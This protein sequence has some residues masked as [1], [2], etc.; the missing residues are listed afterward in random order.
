MLLI[1]VGH[2][3]DLDLGVVGG[4]RGNRVDLLAVHQNLLQG[5][6][7]S[8]RGVHTGDILLGDQDL[9]L[10]RDR[11]SIANLNIVLVVLDCVRQLML[12]ILV[13]HKVDLDLGV[14]GGLRGNRVDLLAVHQNLLQGVAK[15]RR[16]VHTGDILLGD[17]DLEL[18]R[19]RYSIANLNIVLVVLDCVRQLMLLILVEL[20]LRRQGHIMFRHCENAAAHEEGTAL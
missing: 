6:A 8:R 13:G 4:L 15:S 9:E 11:Y 20:P 18:I 14:V 17:Q 16:G 10:I 5:V 3:V 19:D 12:L 1:L 7:K 2:K